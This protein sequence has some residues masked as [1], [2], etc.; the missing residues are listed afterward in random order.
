MN[1]TNGTATTTAPGKQAPLSFLNPRGHA[2]EIGRTLLSAGG[3][4]L[5]LLVRA[6][7]GRL[8][9]ARIPE[10]GWSG[11]EVEQNEPL[12]Q[13]QDPSSGQAERDTL[14]AGPH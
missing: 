3:I 11:R 12:Q 10:E 5:L 4:A 14:P 9:C 2:S 1:R 6:A 13:L 7:A 8:L